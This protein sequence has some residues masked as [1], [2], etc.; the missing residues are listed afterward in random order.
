MSELDKKNRNWK[1]LVPLGDREMADVALQHAIGLCKIFE[2]S[3]VL[4]RCISNINEEAEAKQ[5]L[6]KII[7]HLKMAHGINAE[8]FAPTGNMKQLLFAIAAK[9]ESILVVIGHN[10]KNTSLGMKLGRCLRFMSKSRTPFIMCPL[11]TASHSYKNIAISVSYHRQEK[12]KILWASY[13]GRINNSRISV[14]IPNARDGFFA[15]G[16]RSNLMVLK[17][18]YTNLSLEFELL[19]QKTNVH[20]IHEAAMDWSSEHRMGAYLMLT[21]SKLDIF[22]VLSGSVEKNACLHPSGIPVLCI[23]PRD[24]LYVLCN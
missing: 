19:I 14:I 6:A 9:T 8:A 10:G 17:K 21:T 18:L 4:I 22:D 23:N 7:A 5:R 20:H 13:L 16:I 15:T 11:R 2:A 12:E 1:L 24:D 3:L